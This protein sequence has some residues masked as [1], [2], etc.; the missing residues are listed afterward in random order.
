MVAYVKLEASLKAIFGERKNTVA[1]CCLTSGRHIA[2]VSYLTNNS[3]FIGDR[4]WPFIQTIKEMF[5]FGLSAV[6]RIS[7]YAF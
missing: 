2:I 6:G 4:N 7:C 5:L 3:V 1:K